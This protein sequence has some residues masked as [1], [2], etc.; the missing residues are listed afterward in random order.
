VMM[1]LLNHINL[2][3]SGAVRACF[4]LLI[5]ILFTGAPSL[6]ENLSLFRGP[7]LQVYVK[8][9]RLDSLATIRR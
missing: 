8:R 2:D 7:P 4:L 5:I 9:F 3:S 1:N 6:C